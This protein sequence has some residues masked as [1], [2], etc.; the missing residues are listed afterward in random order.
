MKSIVLM[1]S[2]L[3]IMKEKPTGNYLDRWGKFTKSELKFIKSVAKIAHKEPYYVYRQDNG[4][5]AMLFNDQRIVLGKDG[6]I[7]DLHIL[8]NG[9]WIDLGPEY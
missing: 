4:K 1:L 5:I 9:E 6:F 2:L 8:E 3:G 7:H